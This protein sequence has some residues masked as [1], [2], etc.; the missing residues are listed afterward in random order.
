MPVT[1]LTPKNSVTR[2]ICAYSWLVGKPVLV[3]AV[4]YC[5]LSNLAFEYSFD[6]SLSMPRAAQLGLVS[7]RF[8]IRHASDVVLFKRIGP[9]MFEYRVRRPLVAYSGIPWLVAHHTGLDLLAICN[10]T[11]K[12]GCK[13]Q[14][15]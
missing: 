5:V 9:G 15:G 11:G 8:A 10:V 6:G 4:A 13:I 3:I 1:A 2:R 7:V 14:T 12:G